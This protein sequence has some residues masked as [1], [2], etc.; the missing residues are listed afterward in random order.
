MGQSNM[1]TARW[2]TTAA[3]SGALIAGVLSPAAASGQP[4]AAHVNWSQY[5]YSAAHSSYNKAAT[6]ITPANA[7]DLTEAWQFQ[8]PKAPIKGLHGFLS[9][10]TVYNGVIYI[11]AENGYFYAINDTTGAVIWSVFVGY[12]T[13]KTCGA[14]GFTSTATVAPDPTTGDPTVYVYGASGYLYAFNAADGTEVWP[15]AVVAIPSTT[16]NDYYAWSSPLVINGKIYVGVSSQC[17]LP[18]VQARL[19]AF[20]Q[21]TGTLD[22]TFY[23]TPAGTRGASIWSSPGTDGSA[24]FITTGNGIAKS[25]G[26]SV[27]KLNASLT[28]MLG[29]WT[30][31]VAQ[32]VTDSDFGGSPG[33][34]PAT[35]NG[36]ATKMVGAC[37][38]NGNFYAFATNHLSKG[39]VWT[40]AIADPSG[41]G[42]PG[43]CDAAPIWDGSHLYLSTNATTIGGTAVGGSVQEVNT[44][45]G[46]PLW[47]TGVTGA[48][49]GT[50][51][52]DGAGVIAAATYGSSS[53]GVFLINAATGALLNTIHYAKSATF[54]QPV[55][56][57]NYL[58]VASKGKGLIAYN[59]AG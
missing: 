46:A 34:W 57:D 4:Q 12:V 9:S 29:I 27:V 47:Q 58:F 16:K 2:L 59:V 52:M 33:F 43:E 20:D 10:P 7:A 14:Q 38:K 17:D 28:K 31:P 22:N 48:V 53:N 5:L 40:A 24:I 1:R 36:V 35:I 18:L 19:D 21:A 23:T 42:G 26:F 54:G 15:P 45:T 50:P 30:V 6:A 25:D 8:P 39:P 37:N 11:G 41:S 44:A 51:G 3:I 56:A 13:H 55:F 49:I 32:R